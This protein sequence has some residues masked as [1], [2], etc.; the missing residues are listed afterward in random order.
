[1]SRQSILPGAVLILLYS[2]QLG[3][4]ETDVID[5][6]EAK[7][8]QNQAG[9]EKYELADP[10]NPTPGLK[11]L[12]PIEGGET[13]IKADVKLSNSLQNLNKAL[14]EIENKLGSVSFAVEKIKQSIL[15]RAEND[16]FVNISFALQS[17]KDM[18][19]Q[20]IEARLDDF[21]IYDNVNQAR[22]WLPAGLISLFYGPLTPGTHQLDIS[23][24]LVKRVDNPIPAEQEMFKAVNKRI[25]LQIPTGEF[26]KNWQ[27][28]VNS[29]AS[30]LVVEETHGHDSKL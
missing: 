15:Q 4:A 17:S 29:E 9:E 8:F 12:P 30:D 23:V 6:L 28:T 22:L 7:L 10:L 2:T 26:S 19:L 27:I 13:K 1:M 20:S 24:R 21:L 14:Q 16:N 11:D 3:F 18:G 25:E 5:Q